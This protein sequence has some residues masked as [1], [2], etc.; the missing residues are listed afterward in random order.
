[1]L[2]E[3]GMP[4]SMGPV[5]QDSGMNINSSM[6][7][8]T[9][10]K[11]LSVTADGEAAEQ[12][13]QVLKMAGLAGTHDHDHDHEGRGKVVLVTRGG[14]EEV[15]EDFA[16]EPNQQYASTDTIVDAGQDLNRKKKQY[17]DKPKAGDNPMATEDIA[18][19]G[20]LAA[21]YNSL[22]ITTK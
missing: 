8:K 3:C 14:G 2:S 4:G 20:R 10:R 1:M 22:K 16:N 17:A 19:E 5:E 11:T 15:A 18:L 13:A 7:T 6:D 21:L 9:G 12:L